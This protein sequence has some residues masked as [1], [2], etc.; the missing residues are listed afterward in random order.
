MPDNYS[1]IVQE[2][3]RM[4][5]ENPK[6]KSL[7]FQAFGMNCVI[8]PEGIFLKGKKEEG[9]LGIL[10][11]LYALHAGSE[12]MI[13]EPLKAF[14]DLPNSSPFV[15]AF[16]ARTQ[17][18]LVPHVEAIRRTRESFLKH[19][20]GSPGPH[21]AGGDFSFVL[22]PFPKIALC[23][24]FY[25]ADEDFPASAT[26]LFSNNALTFAPIDALA[27]TAEYTSRAIL[28]TLP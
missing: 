1:K 20:S 23:Y 27:D 25:R 7:E 9:V 26:C 8:Y 5:F 12:E 17:Q 3:I 15:A 2:N 11:S 24:I 14:K 21:G 28:E 6:G 22:K 4:L 16:A 19:L 13:L 10:I 18:V